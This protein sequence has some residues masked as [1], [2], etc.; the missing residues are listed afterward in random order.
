MLRAYEYRPLLVQVLLCLPILFLHF[1]QVPI[2][3]L[4]APCSFQCKVPN[5]YDWQNI[6]VK[7]FNKCSC[8]KSAVNS[9]NTQNLSAEIRELKNIMGTDRVPAS[10][11]PPAEPRLF[12][13]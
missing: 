9:P 13:L 8:L 6:L 11:D 2:N 1:Y 7:F 5:S 4:T 10:R 12:T 3:T